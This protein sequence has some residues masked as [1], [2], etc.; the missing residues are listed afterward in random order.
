MDLAGNFVV[1]CTLDYSASDQDVHA[2]RYPQRRDTRH[3]R[4][5]RDTIYASTTSAN[6]ESRLSIAMGWDG[7]FSI[8]YQSQD[9]TFD[10]DVRMARFSTN[11]GF[12]A[13]NRSRTAP[14]SRS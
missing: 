12:V 2:G 13:T 10:Y 6:D 8:A 4:R 5:L 3:K 7:R 11:V 9:P 14:P 1:T